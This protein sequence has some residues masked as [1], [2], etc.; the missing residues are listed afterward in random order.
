MNRYEVTLTG[1]SPMLMNNDNLAWAEAMNRWRLDP[2][3]K[4]NSVAGDDRSPAWRWIGTLY[5]EG[6][7]IVVPSDN[8]MTVLREGGKKVPTGKSQESFG[9]HTQSGI[10]VDQSAWTMQANG[11]REI[12]FAPIK[13]L[14]EEPDFE[15]HLQTVEKLGF[16]LFVKRAKIG[17][18]KHVRVRPR[19]DHWVLSGTLTVLDERITTEVLINI[20][21][22]AGAYCGVGDWRPSSPKSAGPFGK[23][24][25]TVQ[26]IN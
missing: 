26:E 21:K 10:I 5:I 1:E 19:F 11:H 6:G 24:T 4:P 16:E 9:R 14:I 25:T 12:P 20:C 23:F 7:K 8:L 3:N 17:A 2:A 18:A 15:K 13:A 22:Q